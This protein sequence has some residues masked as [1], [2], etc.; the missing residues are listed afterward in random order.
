MSTPAR[1]REDRLEIVSTA[2][3]K[4]LLS[5]AAAAENR[6]ISAFVLDSGLTAAAEALAD[7]TEFSISSDSYNAFLRVLDAPPAPRPRLDRLSNT[8]SVLD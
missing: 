3:S 5:K 1:R 2:E 8:P 7:R 4:A 6:S